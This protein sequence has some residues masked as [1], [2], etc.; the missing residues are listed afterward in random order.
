MI[1]NF[2]RVLNVVCFLL[3]D[4]PTSELY[5]PTFRNTLFHLHRQVSACARTYLPMK[6]EQSVPKLRH[7]K[8]RRRG[9]TQKKAYNNSLQEIC[10][11]L[12]YYAASS[13][14]FLPMRPIGCPETSRNYHYSLRNSP[15]ERIFNLFRGGSLKSRKVASNFR[16]TCHD[17][18]RRQ[19]RSFVTSTFRRTLQKNLKSQLTF[20]LLQ[21]L[22][23][24]TET[25]GK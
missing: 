9:I 24:A 16:R 6:M 18:I 3:G 17:S 11:F 20:C 19:Y 12:G 22:I 13:G 21:C 23:S 10:A 2:R 4:S 7:I 1:S 8:F 15:E 14:D 25:D 5:M